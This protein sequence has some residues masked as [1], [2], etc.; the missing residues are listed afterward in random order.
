[1][2]DHFAEV[3]LPLATWTSLGVAEAVGMEG[4]RAVIAA[5]ELAIAT[6]DATLVCV[7][8]SETFLRLVLHWR[9][10]PSSTTIH[11]SRCHWEVSK[12]SHHKV[13]SLHVHFLEHKFRVI[14]TIDVEHVVVR[15]RYCD[16]SSRPADNLGDIEDSPK[17]RV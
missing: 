13:D 6:T 1:M 14:P 3:P 16:W 9:L 8:V 2:P 10:L 17:I 4:T 7:A 15:K 11:F 12:A 5:D